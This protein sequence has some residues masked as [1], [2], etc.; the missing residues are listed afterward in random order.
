MSEGFDQ[1]WVAVYEKKASPMK[2][3][4]EVVV[5][6]LM[7]EKARKKGKVLRVLEVGC[8]M[9]N[10][11]WFAA[12]EGFDVSGFDA[13]PSAIEYAVERFAAEGL[14]GD[15]R[16]GL[17]GDLPYRDE[18]FDIVLDC[19]GLTCTGRS[20][21]ERTIGE[22][23]RCLKPDGVFLFTPFDVS[24]TSY[25]SSESGPDGTRVN[26]TGGTVR[27]VGGIAFYSETDVQTV[28]STG[29]SWQMFERYARTDFLNFGGGTRALWNVVV[30]KAAQA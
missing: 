16:V 5:R 17:F 24:D 6:V 2:Y 27:G 14:A 13:V 18:E 20:V 30:R 9:G 22:I 19:G 12:R 28:F 3:P 1:E 26:I 10:N 15:F 25:E 8:G 11:L 23:R 29:W 4:Y 7:G 21:A